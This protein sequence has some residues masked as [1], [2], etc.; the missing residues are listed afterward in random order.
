MFFGNYKLYT[1]SHFLIYKIYNSY[2]NFANIVCKAVYKSLINKDIIA[3]TTKF[4]IK[5]NKNIL[6]YGLKNASTYE[7]MIF[8]KNVRESLSIDNN[9]R[10]IVEFANRACSVP[11]E[12]N[13]NKSNANIFFKNIKLLRKQLIYTKT[14]NGKEILLRHKL[15]SLY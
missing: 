13:K 14:E 15:Q 11:E 4:Y 8:L 2:T 12:F 7:Q 1:F 6:E 3:P 10:Y 9:S 5:T